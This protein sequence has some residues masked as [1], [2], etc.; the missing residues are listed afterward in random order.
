[1]NVDE[2]ARE[3][4]RRET[5]TE[6]SLVTLLSLVPAFLLELCLAIGALLGWIQ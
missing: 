6:A 1:M 4:H 3:R 5:P 2:K